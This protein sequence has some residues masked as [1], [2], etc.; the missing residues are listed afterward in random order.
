[1]RWF[2]SDLHFGHANIVRFCNRPFRDPAGEPD[3]DAMREG[4]LNRINSVVGP[5]DELWILGDSIMGNWQQSMNIISRF[6]AG[7]VVLVAGNH[8][9]CH[10]SDRRW[11]RFL[12]LY[13]DAFDEVHTTSTN[14]L[15]ADNTVV[16]SHFPYSLS[17]QEARAR[18]GETEVSDRFAAWRPVDQGNWLFC[19]HVHDAWRQRGRQVNVGIDAWG[20][21]PVS[22][23][24]LTDILREGPHDRDIL[25][26]TT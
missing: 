1:M 25:T 22:E 13:Q 15:I 16:V 18:R 21:M 8:D 14:I 2:T 23:S 24:A 6:T 26:W 10:P 12:P 19:G 4:I 5:Q 9:R 3:V 11:E 7:R 20:G 17:P